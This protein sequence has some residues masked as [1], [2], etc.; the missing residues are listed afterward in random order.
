ML[1]YSPFLTNGPPRALNGSLHPTDA[2]ELVTVYDSDE[3][4]SLPGGLSSTE[5]LYALQE[6]LSTPA[7]GSVRD[8]WSDLDVQ[9]PLASLVDAMSLHGQ[10]VSDSTATAFQWP[11]PGVARQHPLRV[12]IDVRASTLLFARAR[13]AT[14]TIA[15]EPIGG[16]AVAATA[17]RSQQLPWRRTETQ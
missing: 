8:R 1:P 7:F 5:A 14:G 12:S 15:P 2:P 17:P 3:P 10:N 13:I 16:T 4:W 11:G 6:S 9:D